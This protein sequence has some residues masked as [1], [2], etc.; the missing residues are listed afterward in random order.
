[1]HKFLATAIITLALSGAAFA[2]TGSGSTG[3]GAAGGT[4]GGTATGA[5]NGSAGSSGTT[6]GTAG[7]N[8]DNDAKFMTKMGPLSTGFFGT[9]NS[10]RSQDEVSAAYKALNADQQAMMNSECK[11]VGGGGY[12]EQVT[13]LC[14][15][16]GK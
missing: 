11:T 12:G 5:A 7:A 6:T 10:V 2:Q 1:M 13:S 8:S 9:D 3:D 16:I 4:A 15:L 14:G